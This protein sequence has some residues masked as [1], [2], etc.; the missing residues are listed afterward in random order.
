MVRR[1]YSATPVGFRFLL[2]CPLCLPIPVYLTTAVYYSIPA[3]TSSMGS[4]QIL[5][6]RVS[7]ELYSCLFADNSSGIFQRTNL[8]IGLVLIVK[9]EAVKH[10]DVKS[11]F[12][13][14]MRGALL[15]VTI[16]LIGAGWA[17]IKHVLSER[18]KKL[19]LII[20][21]LQV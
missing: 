7:L 5:L 16:I 18:E 2:I 14:S 17:F 13:F 20:I 21:P 15:F 6:L 1:I 8:H 3:L 9:Q 12:H 4:S 11:C 19:F 10:V